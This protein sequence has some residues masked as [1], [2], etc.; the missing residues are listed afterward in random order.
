MPVKDSRL[1][2]KLKEISRHYDILNGN[3]LI[4]NSIAAMQIPLAEKTAMQAITEQSEYYKNRGYSFDE[5]YNGVL[6]LAAFTYRCKKDILPQLRTSLSF[7]KAQRQDKVLEQM[8]ADNFQANLA[9]MADL[10]NELYMICVE[11]DRA[12]NK[13]GTPV[14]KSIKELELFGLLLTDYSID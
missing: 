12:A 5:L 2:E 9:I 10:I 1:F 6:A 11:L 14:Y 13:K 7:S 3:K 4:R 8:A